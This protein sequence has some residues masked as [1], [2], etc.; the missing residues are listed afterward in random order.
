MPEKGA[1]HMRRKSRRAENKLLDLYFR[2]LSG[3]EPLSTQEEGDL[4]RKAREGDREARNKLIVANLRFVIRLAGQYQSYGVALEDLIG[5]GNVGLITATE[6]FDETRGFRFISYATWWIRRAI[7][8][9]L[10][11][12]PRPIRIPTNR[13]KLLK[14]IAQISNCLGHRKGSEPDLKAIAKQLGV[15]PALMEDT[16]A[17]SKRV[18]S[19]DAPLDACADLEMKHILVDA[20]QD[21]PDKEVTEQSDRKQVQKALNTLEDRETK[22]L[23]MYYGMGRDN[24]LTLEQIGRYL[25]LTRERVRQIK[26]RALSKLRH[27][28]RR[29]L[30]EALR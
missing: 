11:D 10:L 29:F 13:H 16:L 25:G 23:S 30:L 8:Q 9:T 20:K 22:V 15:S 19:L 4:T 1:I 5:A 18:V 27:P 17:L 7:H 12:D 3:S 21:R 2:D 24:S 14:K 6:R 28:K 26:D